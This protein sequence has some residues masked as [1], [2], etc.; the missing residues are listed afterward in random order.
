MRNPG[1]GT[2]LHSQ[3]IHCLSHQI[4]VD[5][6]QHSCKLLRSLVDCE[7]LTFPALSFAAEPKQA[8]KILD[9]ARNLNS[10]KYKAEALRI[11][12]ELFSSL[13]GVLA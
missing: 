9:S 2:P 6:S 5:V 1:Y 4:V 13:L 10:K 7:K 3:N 8:E 12:A 11:E